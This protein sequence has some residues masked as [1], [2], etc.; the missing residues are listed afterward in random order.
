M[1]DFLPR[2]AVIGECLV[3]LK[4]AKAPQL[5][6]GFGGDSFNTAVYMARLGAG[7]G[8]FVDY[9]SAVGNDHFS[10][11]MVAFWQA[12]NIGTGLT[13]I[14]SG[15]AA[16]LYLVSVDAA[17]ERSFT[18]WRNDSAAR[19]M[20]ETE[21]SDHVL[22]ALARYNL[23]YLSGISL[24][25][26]RPRSRER[27]LSRL[28][29]LSRAGIPIAFDGNHRPILWQNPTEAR[30]VWERLLPLVRWVLL[31][32]E[33]LAV[34]GVQPDVNAG[35][36]FFG[37]WP[38]IEWVLKNGGNPCHIRHGNKTLQIPAHKAERIT[39]TT[40]AGDS[41]SAAYLLTRLLGGDI[42][43]SAL[44]AH[45]LAAKVIA[46][47]GAIIPAE[48]MPDLLSDRIKNCQANSA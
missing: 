8:K 26:L 6:Y 32:V 35:V 38:Q 24:A 10:Q 37:N 19:D 18:Y 4:D 22:E 25:I 28:E 20:F 16:G 45:E 29:T 1:T 43:D 31:T 3:E 14:I 12:Q 46:H 40:A 47:S 48:F 30:Q 34:M 13:S 36:E 33:E 11:E 21:V 7:L 5:T 2:I 39:D 23:I 27:L 17:G 9:V 44:M 15:H 42:T 41:F